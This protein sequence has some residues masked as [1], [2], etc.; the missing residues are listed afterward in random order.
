MTDLR[1]W[2]GLAVFLVVALLVST[3]ADLIRRAAEADQRCRQAELAGQLR[4]VVGEQQAAL[5]RVATLV[6]RGVNPLE[7]LAAVARELALVLDVQ[8]AAVWRYEPDGA[9]TLVAAHDAPDAKKMP[10]GMRFALEGNNVAA[11]VLVPSPRP[12]G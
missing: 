10:V 11:M 6:A 8:N 12:D 1:D 2:V 7:L 4:N 9:A 5:R 3:L